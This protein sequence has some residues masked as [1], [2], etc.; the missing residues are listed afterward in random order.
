MGLS[1]YP[2]E[3]W[4]AGGDGGYW[5]E[6]TGFETG[7]AVRCLLRKSGKG[8]CKRVWWDYSGSESLAWVWCNEPQEGPR[9]CEQRGPN[10]ISVSV[11]T[12]SYLISLITERTPCQK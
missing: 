12:R 6:C 1:C 4:L 7:M 2:T 5:A 8:P 11:S 10:G 3:E 9:S